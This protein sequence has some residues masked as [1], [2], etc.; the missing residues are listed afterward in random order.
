MGERLIKLPWLTD[1]ELLKLY[2]Y[3][4]LCMRAGHT[5]Q[6]LDIVGKHMNEEC[7]PLDKL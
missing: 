7:P 1:K 6:A 4:F 2:E 5:G 3:Y